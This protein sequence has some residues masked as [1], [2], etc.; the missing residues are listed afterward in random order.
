MNRTIFF[1]NII[2]PILS[3]CPPKIAWSVLFYIHHKYRMNWKKP[4]TYDE[5]LTWLEV[6]EFDSRLNKYVDKYEA[7]NYIMECGFA[8]NL[9][10]VYGVWDRPESI[11][12]DKLPSK[13]ILKTTQG[14]GDEF[15]YIC[16]DKFLCDKNKIVDK[17]SK[18]ISIEF[19]RRTCEYQYKGIKPR[20]FAE[21][22]LDLGKGERMVDYKVHCFNGEPECVLVCSNR[23]GGII[24]LGLLRFKLELYRYCS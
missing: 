2:N 10:E 15:Y 11:E 24:M 1:Q 23:G 16:Q 9:P 17:F 21:E 12:W 22:L 8:K 4:T 7:R 5:K 20:I 6:T 14:A 18:A 3:F 13:F 19:W